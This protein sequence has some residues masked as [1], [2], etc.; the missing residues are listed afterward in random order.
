[1]PAFA[2]FLTLY[3]DAIII[4]S[5]LLIFAG[6]NQQRVKFNTMSECIWSISEIMLK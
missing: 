4:E 3:C 6:L 2:S 5:I 1:M